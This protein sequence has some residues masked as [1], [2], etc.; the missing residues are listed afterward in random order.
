MTQHSE[1]TGGG[2]RRQTMEHRP[3][4]SAGGVGSCTPGGV[5]P[6]G[7]SESGEASRDNHD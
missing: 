6:S 7:D 1:P 5:W 4:L 3:P 2:N